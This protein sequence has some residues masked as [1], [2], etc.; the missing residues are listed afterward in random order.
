M[1]RRDRAAAAVH[2]HE[3]AGREPGHHDGADVDRAAVVLEPGG[4]L[5]EVLAGE[6]GDG[7]EH[8]GAGVEQEAAAG[9][10]RV[11]APRAGRRVAQSCQTTALMLRIGP[12]SPERSMPDASRTC[13]ERLPWKATTSSRPVRSRV[14]ISAAA[15]SAS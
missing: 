6:V 9:Q 7:V 5:G 13:G 10:R 12:S 3:R 1:A 4:D 2:R 11:L 14:S 15:S 8:V